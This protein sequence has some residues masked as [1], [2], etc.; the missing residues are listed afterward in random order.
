MLVD[1]VSKYEGEIIAAKSYMIHKI[2]AKQE[3]AS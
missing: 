1:G 3:L 2:E